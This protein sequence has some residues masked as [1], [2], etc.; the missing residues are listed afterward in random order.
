MAFS[1]TEAGSDQGKAVAAAAAGTKLK[2]W[3]KRANEYPAANE[4]VAYNRPRTRSM[5]LPPSGKR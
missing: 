5:C 3:L 2:A 1:E 4:E